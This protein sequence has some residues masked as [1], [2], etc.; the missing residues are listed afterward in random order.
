MA[1]VPSSVTHVLTREAV[2]WSLEQLGSRNIDPAFLYYLYLREQDL[3][4]ELASASPKSAEVE[5]LMRVPGGPTDKP[6]YR[7]LK[8]SGAGK[9]E[10][11]R[12]SF[13]IAENIS[14]S[15]S[16][17]SLKRLKMAGWLVNDEFQYELP[18]DHPRLAL[19]NLLLGTKVSA[20][21]FGGYVL[22]NDGFVLDGT[23]TPYDIIDG[24]RD[25]FQLGSEDE[26][27]DM[28]FDTDVPEPD[29][30]DFDWFEPVG[31]QVGDH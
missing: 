13:W 4:G 28:L 20:L 17:K 21:A 29:A 10:V 18:P 9:G 3:R 15:W 19:D 8:E 12:E 11:L 23:P 22:R 24:L 25:R 16:P 2:R 6:F 5:Y 1:A 30:V 31:P 26:A 14:G 7:P 27:F